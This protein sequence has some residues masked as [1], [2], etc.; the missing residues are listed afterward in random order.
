[1]F[2][3]LDEQIKHDE[4]TSSTVRER[5]IRYASIVLVSV[6]AFGGLYAGIMLLQ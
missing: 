2:S 6:L 5:F 1:M 3:S 4:Q